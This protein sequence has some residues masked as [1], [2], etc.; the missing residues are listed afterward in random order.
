[1]FAVLSGPAATAQFSVLKI[2]RVDGGFVHAVT[3]TRPLVAHLP[4]RGKRFADFVKLLGGDPAYSAE[5]APGGASDG[6]RQRRARKGR[7]YY[8]GS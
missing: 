8:T 4:G 2:R 3:G 5:A 6:A 1:M 7:G